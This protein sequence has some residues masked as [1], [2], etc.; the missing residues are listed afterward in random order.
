MEKILE[1]LETIKK[2]TG[3]PRT[4]GLSEAHLKPF[5]EQSDLR[6]AVAMAVATFD[7]LGAD[8]KAK[9]QQDEEQNLRVFQAGFLNF[10]PP[11]SVTTYIPLAAKGPWIISAYG[12]VI[13]DAGG[14]G[15]LGHGHNPDFIGPL[16]AK[17]QVMA[18]IMTPSLQQR[19]FADRLRMEI[20]RSRKGACPFHQFIAMNSGSEAGSVA[21]R[22]SDLHAKTMTDPGAKYDGKEIKILAC[23]GAFHGR[24]GRPARA[25]NSCLKKYK[26]LAS[27]RN[28]EGTLIVAPNDV[29]GLERTFKEVDAKGFYIELMMLEPVMGEGNPG[30]A[31]TPEFYAAARRLTR[32]HE[33][34]LIVDS[35]QA[36]LRAQGVLS[37][38]DYPGFQD[39]DAPDMEMYSKAVNAGQF[40]V[41]VLA[42]SKQISDLYLPGIYGNT[43]TA[44]PRA[45]E[46][47]MGVL[48]EVTPELRDNICKQGVNFVA[49]LEE[50]QKEFPEKLTK[51]QGTGLIVSCELGAGLQALGVGSVEEQMRLQGVNVIHGGENSLRFTPAFAIGDQEINLI[52]QVLRENIS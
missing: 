48:D 26:N 6:D 50:L 28:Y 11:E 49:A 9:L 4:R 8:D 44:N 41:S 14:Y 31:I 35:V 25:S 17:P 5:L 43:M 16:L 27:F 18:N 52:I 12:A 33:T 24:T 37:I 40:P 19:Q 39:L 30:L 21:T 34:F 20:G 13:Y 47:T 46:L 15:M 42:V 38:V 51:V 2:A 29:E 45:L 23:K 3:T 32:A 7:A 36:G 1:P 22:I 10:Y